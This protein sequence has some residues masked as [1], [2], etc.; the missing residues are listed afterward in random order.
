MKK[1]TGFIIKKR[2]FFCILFAVALV[3]SAVCIPFV[4]V[5][6]DDTWYLP[7]S[8]NTKAGISV[9]KSEFGS[10]GTATAMLTGADIAGILRI[11]SEISAVYGVSGVVWLDE[12]ILPLAG[13]T[14]LTAAETIGYFLRIIKVLPRSEEATPYDIAIA[15]KSE[16]T[17]SEL[18]YV[19]ALMNKMMSMFS[20][21]GKSEFEDL[22][23]LTEP[24]SA[25]YLLAVAGMKDQ[26]GAAISQTG[27]FLPV[28]INSVIAANAG[29]TP[30]S[31]EQAMEYLAKAAAVL[32][33]SEG[34]VFADIFN[35]L[36]S[37]FT[38]A[39]LPI[40]MKLIAG[41]GI[42]FSSVDM[43]NPY[44]M[45]SPVP[46]GVLAGIAAAKEQLGAS[47]SVLA[48][49]GSM[50]FSLTDKVVEMN[51]SGVTVSG[52]DA[53]AYLGRLMNTLPDVEGT[54]NYGLLTALTSEFSS[55]E[56]PYILE[57]LSGLTGGAFE[58]PEIDAAQIVAV[59]S[60]IGN[61]FTGILTGLDGQ[62]DS[63][64][65][66]GSALF[67]ITFMESDYAKTT[68]K[69]I[70]DIIGLSDSIYLSGN[71][72]AN[73]YQRQLM[74]GEIINATV[75]V[76]VIALVILFLMSS[77][78]LDP[79]L[80]IIVIVVAIVLNMGTNL[81]F[82]SVS[83]LTE[84]VASILQLALSIDYA[85]FLL[86]RYKK[87]R[88]EGKGAEEA[89]GVALVRSF[90][91]I[92]ASSLTTVACFI[93]I[94]FMQYRLGLDMGVVMAKGIILSLITVFFLLPGIVVYLDRKITKSE[95]KTFRFNCR[96]LSRFSYKY[97]WLLAALAVVI[98]IPSAFISGQNTF[99]Y[100]VSAMQGEDSAAT[101]NRRL[102]ESTFGPQEQLVL[103]VPKDSEKELAITERLAATDGI[104]GVRSW[105]QTEKSGFSNLLPATVRAQ[106]V[107]SSGYNRIVLTLNCAEE[108]EETKALLNVIRSEI[109]D[110][111]NTGAG[112]YLLGNTAAAIDM[113]ESTNDDFNRI[114]AY[115]I[116]A[117]ALIVAIS[118]GSALIP[119]ILVF[120]I[121]GA[122][123]MNMSIP[124]LAGNQM[125]FLGYMIISNILLGATID[126]A[127][128]FTSNY[129][130]ARQTLD[131]PGSVQ[132]AQSNSMRSILTSGGIFTLGGLV[133]GLTSSFPTVQLLG[134][135]IMRGGI[136][137]TLVTVFVLPAL[138]AILDKPIRKLTW[139]K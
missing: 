51:L 42:D 39:E 37:A 138:L 88:A 13:N 126:Y 121:E 74:T 68:N 93:T 120:V 102:I 7:D 99:T 47:A 64:Y 69:A 101:Q 45:S 122:V 81:I 104:D 6:Y 41:F 52:E 130:E 139:R 79:L 2:L 131:K 50:F 73:Y 4:N 33:A 53:V 12:I 23:L 14:G 100:G 27:V 109:T 136:F 125:I 134:Y 3:A 44:V 20:G 30:L 89:M 124:L 106:L 54:D 57:A 15:L 113:E 77:S 97:R 80:Y 5:N 36:S 128:L 83:Y 135:S 19:T 78:R 40:V 10:G 82:G 127:I 58:I 8:S 92:S 18:P 76:V 133:L 123:W 32:P 105:V 103:L 67:T 31:A 21:G 35:S 72:A 107:G 55:E 91:P 49:S 132:A 95:H 26:L 71:A 70:G 112:V 116:V 66:D 63:L 59:S 84:S 38:K 43:T 48:D 87:E 24:V 115:S 25:E 46:A 114:S 60:P 86:N 129:M 16:F 111:Y 85:I 75:I 110:V 61:S 34:T 29:G 28:F 22:M 9:N 90:S 17:G 56:L 94:M 1:L 119:V 96:S 62:I 11:K 137:A 108:G 65:K 118:F 98:I 117:V